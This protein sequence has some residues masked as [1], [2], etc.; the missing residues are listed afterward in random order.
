MALF[1]RFRGPQARRV[2]ACSSTTSTRRTSPSGSRARGRRACA[3]GR[4][5]KQE[6]PA[7][8]LIGNSWESRT[9]C[10]AAVSDAA[11]GKLAPAA[12]GVT[13]TKRTKNSAQPVA[14]AEDSRAARGLLVTAFAPNP[15][16]RG[17]L[18]RFWEQVGEAGTYMVRLPSGMNARAAQPCDLRGQPIGS[19]LVV[20]ENG[21][22]EMEIGPMAPIS[23]LLLQKDGT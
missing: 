12:A 9:S 4:R 21:T 7:E 18:L 6:S 13:V 17:M 16:G 15:Y 14:S 3:C 11:P 10:L 23:V 5:G 19:P 20:S 22:F 8:S 1:A 2:R